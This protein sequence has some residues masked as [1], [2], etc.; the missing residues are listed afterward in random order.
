MDAGEKWRQR[1]QE[2]SVR[3]G[4]AKDSMSAIPGLYAAYRE[5]GEQDRPMVDAVIAE[6]V[7]SD[8]ETERFDALALVDEF[9]I[10]VAKPNLE[11][12][13]ERLKTSDSPGA[14]WE[15]EKV[16]R[17]LTQFVTR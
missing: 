8:V 7:E 4:Q 2:I 5:V 15:R 16:D 12:L 13:A 10:R 14:P 11:R 17:I 6:A 9:H 3:A 1:W